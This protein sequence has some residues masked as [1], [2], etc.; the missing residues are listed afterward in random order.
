LMVTI[1]GS[2]TMRPS[3]AMSI[4]LVRM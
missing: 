3:Q 4:F 2:K 1:C